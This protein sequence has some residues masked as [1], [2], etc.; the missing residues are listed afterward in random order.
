MRLGVVADTH[1]PDRVKALPPRMFELLSGVDL[2]LHAG[3]LSRPGVLGELQALAPVVAVQGNRDIFYKTNRSL[4]MHRI[5]EVGA[6]RIGLTHGHGG[7]AEYVKEK[8]LFLA[9]GAFRYSRYEVQVRRWF[10]DVQAIVFGHTH[11][12]VCKR[13]DGILLFNP[14]SVGPDYKLK[15]GASVGILTVDTVAQ[16]IE[17]QILVLNAETPQRASRR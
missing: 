2:I 8:F 5:I 12:P 17:G 10:S 6:L 15:S 11:F 14:G 13:V 4:P 3:D 1:V 9:T 16:K 7:L